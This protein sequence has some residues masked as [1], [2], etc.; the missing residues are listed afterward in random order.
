MR[1][2]S[3][4][5][6]AA[7]LAAPA[8]GAE[9][10]TPFEASGARALPS[11]AEISGY[12]ARLVEARPEA[13]ALV[14]LGTSAGGR[15]LEALRLSDR[16]AFLAEG[17][18]DPATA[19][20][21]LVGSQHGTE[22]SGAEALQQLARELAAGDLR[23]LLARLD[24]V[25]VANANPDGRDL[26]R[27]TNAARVNLSTDFVLMTQPE[28]RALAGLLRSFAPHAVLDLHE[29][30]LWKRRTLGAQGWLTDFEAQVEHAN[31]P[32]VD[33]RLAAF[34]RE[35]FV[36]AL[37]RRIEA[38]GLRAQPYVGEI[39]DAS[40]VVTHGGLTLRN[41]RNYAGL[42]GALSIL[43]EN[44]L[45]PPGRP[46]PTPR[47][48]A[49][50]V[51]K[52][53]LSARAF[54][55]LVLREGD[56]LRARSDSAR[57]GWRRPAPVTLRVAW[58]PDPARPQIEIPLRRVDTGALVPRRFAYRG[59]IELGDR[60][61]LPAAYVLP[62]A[63]AALRALLAAHGIALEPVSATLDARVVVQRVSAV[64]RIPR[65]IGGVE[66]AAD[67]ALETE[68]SIETRRIGVGAVRVPLGQPAARLAA[69][70]LEPRSSTGIFRSSAFAAGLAPG[71]EL[72]PLRLLERPG[73]GAAASGGERAG[74]RGAPFGYP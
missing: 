22:P 51:R 50:R 40:Q 15:P 69:L 20:V 57:R 1:F 46:Y 24:V 42:G 23:P 52:Q 49:A 39:V 68:E 64:E 25:V 21:L 48:L 72:P 13:A 19:R 36:P 45:D 53:A 38:S 31:H 62:R 59:R 29:S 47:N 61:E 3:A 63:G 17:R 67:V 18:P 44:R 58:A 35:R 33:P 37:L 74:A 9:L 5:A 10:A 60:I 43:V 30:A 70:L 8:G 56:A 65:S 55:E 54:L 2:G 73:T 4:L 11:S 34:A 6:L 14:P 66:V 26:R 41:L 71:D 12:L 32:N 16:A 28:T 7:L 27:R